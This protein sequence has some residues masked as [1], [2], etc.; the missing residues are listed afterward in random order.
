MELL[1]RCVIL[2]VKRQMCVVPYLLSLT[3]KFL[4]AG[5]IHF[6][7]LPQIIV[8]YFLKSDNDAHLSNIFESLL[9]MHTYQ[10]KVYEVSL[11]QKIQTGCHRWRRRQIR[12][13]A[14]RQLAI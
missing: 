2:P 8:E 12:C 10:L 14:D 9:T 5:S 6:A 11:R 7:R 3:R 13:T 1:E 4:F